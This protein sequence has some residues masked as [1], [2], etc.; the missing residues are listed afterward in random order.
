M[1]VLLDV[2][3]AQFKVALALQLQ[4]RVQLV[5]W[6]L[7]GLVQPVVHLTVWSVVAQA[8]GGSVGGYSGPELAA[9]FIALMVVNHLVFTWITYE[10][11][12]LV[13]Q[14]TLAPRLLRPVHPIHWHVVDNLT[15]KALT[16]V[17]MLPAAGLMA[18]IFRPELHTSWWEVA[19]FV[20]ALA[21]AFALRFLIEWSF[22]LIGFWTTRV[23]AFNQAL[24][25]VAI[26]MSGYFAPLAL[27]PP[28]LQVVA[29]VLPFRWGLAF[30]VEVLLGRLSAGE[31]ASGLAA[32]AIWVGLAFVI[33][34]LTWKAGVKQFSAVGA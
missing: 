5:I 23:A 14:G 34:R 2:Y 18:A 25:T 12:F 10:F 3:R 16:M 29:N 26:F 21:L 19:A 32:Q 20:P 24:D 31:V 33:M 13:R 8:S 17:V 9:Y 6:L 30:P 22:A 27:L 15:Y 4:Y 1:A 7:F 28:Q 11:E